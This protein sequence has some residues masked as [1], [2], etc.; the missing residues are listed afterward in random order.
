[1]PEIMKKR[2]LF[3]ANPGTPDVFDP[4]LFDD[5]KDT[6]DDRF[7]VAHR[8]KEWGVLE[9]VDYLAVNITAGESLPDPLEIDAVIVGGSFHSIN[10]NLPWQRDLAAWLERWRQTGRPALGICAGHQMMCAMA[11]L[12][13]TPR[14]DG[15]K[16]TSAAV[17]LT[18]AGRD[19][20][21]FDGFGNHPVFHFGNYDHVL[22][23][24]DDAIV[25][26]NDPESPALALD[27]GD[28]WYSIQFHPEVS[29]DYMARVWVNS[30][31]PEFTMNYP[32]LPEAPRLL[33]NYLRLA[34]L[35]PD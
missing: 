30:S 19:H 16:G 1:M 28:N 24:P 31:T 3:I 23:A 18:K 21:L 32:A 14:S 22:E 17:T 34:G 15:A 35:L 26:A 20:P 4:L 25:L 29:H 27:H 13:V 2:L 11:G 9:A 5:L 12:A 33:V 6:G 10:D 7:F 8:L